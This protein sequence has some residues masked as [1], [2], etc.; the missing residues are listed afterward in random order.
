LKGLGTCPDRVGPTA[1]LER[2]SQMLRVSG[3]HIA[4]SP[5]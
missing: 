3:S 5:V 4:S 2:R 1:I